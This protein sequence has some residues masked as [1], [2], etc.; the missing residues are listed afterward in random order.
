LLWLAFLPPSLL[1]PGQAPGSWDAPP[2]AKQLENPLKTDGKTVERGKRLY[3]HYCIP[4]HGESGVGDG[5]M[6]KK[7]GYQPAN[8]T[9]ERLNAQVDGEIFW[10]VSKGKA[11]MPEFQKEL[12][13][14]D[15]WDVV[16][17]VRTLLKQGQ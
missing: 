9:L 16:S 4:C 14:R 12:S 10:K 2:S 3:R 5:A 11:P 7:L 15:R 1:F 6:A 8:L 17:F 13:D